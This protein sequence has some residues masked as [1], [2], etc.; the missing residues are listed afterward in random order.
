MEPV[1]DLD[2]RFCEVMDSAPVMIW[3]SGPD[4][5][6]TWF[7]KPWLRF[8]G[9]TMEQELGN[10]WTES[11]HPEDLPKCLSVYVSYFDARKPFQMQYRLRSHDGT[12]RWI[13]STGAPRHAS[14]GTFLGYIGS[15]T[16][17]HDSRLAA[18][19]LK[20]LKN[21]LEHEVAE[22][23]KE[24]NAQ[25]QRRQEA[26]LATAEVAAAERDAQNALSRQAQQ[27]RLLIESVVDYAIYL[28]D[29]KGIITSWNQGAERNKGYKAQEIIGKHF[30]TF[31]TPEEQAAG[32]PEQA[33]A[34]AE[35]TGRYE[36]EGWRVRKDGSRFWA[37][38]IIDAI[39]SPEGALLGFAKITR[40]MTEKKKAE[41]EL[42]QAREQLFQIQKLEA[43]GQ[44]T[45]GVAHDFN[46][47]LTIISGNIEIAQRAVEAGGEKAAQQVRRLLANAHTGAKRAATLTQRLL[48]FARRQ[49]LDP[50]PVNVN[51]FITAVGE[52]L[53]RT[54]G[55]QIAVEAVGGGGVWPIEVDAVQLES[56]MLNVALNA[57]DAMPGGGK[58]TIET[59]NTFLDRDYARTNPEVVP[60]QYV[61]ISMTDTGA[62]MPP[63]VSSRAFEPFFTTKMAGQGTGLGLSQVYGFV[64]QSNGHV[65]VYSE[66]GEG[67]TVKI[68][69]P[70]LLGEAAESE[71]ATPDVVGANHGETVLVVEDDEGVLSYVAEVLQMLDYRVL[72]AANGANAIKYLDN[73]AVTIDLLL[74]DVVMPGMNGRALAEE[75]RR[76]RPRIKVLFMTGYSQ[77]AI[78]HQGRL[79]PG[80]HL[81]QKPL[82]QGNLATK[83]R[84]VLDA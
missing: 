59:S 51:R 52:V 50:K 40:D 8:T 55:E 84:D 53:Q 3:V 71:S 73:S 72:R 21:N 74:T 7:N 41:A 4:K 79:D 13:D 34:T 39:R 69:L 70:R 11:V 46:N 81:I 78:V 31:Y 63:E 30:R 5:L 64:K 38:A 67:T 68:Y 58:L 28:V 54:L 15:C 62:G 44:L 66:V 19:E 37:N 12:Y 1:G 22:R 42:A 77:N 26:E 45:G 83:V 65:K 29:P 56:A 27:F 82:S 61:L 43:L 49:P 47:L 16:D 33:L 25:T 10:G 76:L 32:V 48:A 2:A 24:L 75:A 14:D 57:R 36:A 23:T 60:G 20:A 17:V 9:R 6:R 80:V 35:R 18:E